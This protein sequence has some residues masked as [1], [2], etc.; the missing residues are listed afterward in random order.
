MKKTGFR[1][2]QI[3]PSRITFRKWCVRHDE[4]CVIPSF[5]HNSFKYSDEEEEAPT[6]TRQTRLHISSLLINRDKH[7]S[8]AFYREY[9]GV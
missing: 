9:G 1:K 4:R 2:K 7:W 5:T 8:I 3:Q 6:Y